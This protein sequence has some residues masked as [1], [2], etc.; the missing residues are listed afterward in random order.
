M[1]SSP[2]SSTCQE[3]GSSFSLKKSKV[4]LI[5]LNFTCLNLKPRQ[6]QENR[7]GFKGTT[8]YSG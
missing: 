1:T 3:F 6:P 5:T 7:V 8:L 4:G 2:E